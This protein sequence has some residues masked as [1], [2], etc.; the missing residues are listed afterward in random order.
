M[1]SK[2]PRH[3]NGLSNSSDVLG[4]Y[5]TDS[6]GG[7]V[8][9][10]FPQLV[11]MPV[12]NDD[13]VGGMHIYIPWWLEKDKSLPFSRGYHIE[14]W[15]G[16]GMPGYGF[17]GGIHRAND[18]LNGG[19]RTRGG[20]GYGLQLKDDYR[21]LWGSFIGMS[22]RGEM[23][24]RWE[25]HCAIDSQVVDR[26]GIPVLKFDVRWSEEELLQIKHFHETGNEIIRTMGGEPM[27]DIPGADQ[28]YGITRPGQIIHEV[29]TTRMGN[30]PESSVLNK[31][32]QAHE[33]RNV[34]VADAGPFVSQPHKN[35]TWTILAMSMR[36]SEY[37]ASEVLKRN[38][39]TA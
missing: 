31:Y 16:R 22:G 28:D 2:S 33:S 37:I 38:L 17:G 11:D 4:R 6:T 18:K 5:L 26:F 12:H 13:G 8:M 1:N 25:N 34:F 10:Y 15:G 3:P 21:R 29:G 35:P 19:D 36:T 7:D 9:G 20:G 32:S 23:I 30:N 14:T 27:W 39:G 24:A